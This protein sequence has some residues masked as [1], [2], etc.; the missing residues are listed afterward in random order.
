MLQIIREFALEQLEARGEVE[1]TRRAHTEFF[2]ARVESASACLL[3]ANQE[4][5]IERLN[6][7]L[8]DIRA[9][10][11][12]SLEVGEPGRAARIAGALWPYWWLRSLQR[13]AATWLQEVRAA[14]AELS[15]AE[16]A[17][18]ALTLAMMQ[19]ILGERAA[20]EST[21]NSA[22]TLARD[23][24]DAVR[25]SLAQALD[26]AWGM[27]YAR[28]LLGLAS[29]TLGQSYLDLGQPARARPVLVRS[30]ELMSG[31]GNYYAIDRALDALA[32]LATRDGDADLGAV[33]FGAA[34]GSRQ[35]VGAGVWPTD[36]ARREQTEHDLHTTLGAAGFGRR[37]R[38]GAGLGPERALALVATESQSQG[39]VNHDYARPN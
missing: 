39:E 9:A 13:E 8:D 22:Y 6:L 5:W 36:R 29:L 34:E 15:T 25:T 3:T 26:Y 21:L 10:M 14:S 18:T 16:R 11:R 7:D 38:D 37:V 24:A 20:A 12:W 27:A 23:A 2:R 32:S 35:T 28:Y 31:V 30:L 17:A 1:Q 4:R 33:L 19:F